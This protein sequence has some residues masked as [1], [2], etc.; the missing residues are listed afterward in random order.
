MTALNALPAVVSTVVRETQLVRIPLQLRAPDGTS[1]TVG[2]VVVEH[3]FELTHFTVPGKGEERGAPHEPVLRL[4]QQATHAIT[5]DEWAVLKSAA[6]RAWA[7]YDERFGDAVPRF[8]LEPPALEPEAVLASA[9]KDPPP[10]ISRALV[11]AWLEHFSSALH[12]LNIERKQL[13]KAA[14]LIAK[15]EPD[16]EG[17]WHMRARRPP[18]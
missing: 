8:D 17:P 11:V 15:G 6:D 18:A 3:F 10:M 16:R 14:E 5:R 9:E 13:D 1:V 12:P 2:Y 7:L 4:G